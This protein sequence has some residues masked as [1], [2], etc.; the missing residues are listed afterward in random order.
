MKP[1]SFKQ[2]N[3]FFEAGKNP[4]TK[5]MPACIAIDGDTNMPFVVSRWKLT[6]D[7]MRRINQT[8]E[9]WVCIMGQIMPPIMPT[10]FD[11]FLEMNFEPI[12]TKKL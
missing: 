4:N 9:V 2:T 8:G 6:D 5:D 7:E 3:L 10:V 1:T 11:P 12:Q